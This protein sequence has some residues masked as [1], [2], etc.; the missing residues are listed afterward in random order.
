MLLELSAG[1]RANQ[2]V[3]GDLGCGRQA[4]TEHAKIKIQ[5][6]EQMADELRPARNSRRFSV[7][8]RPPVPKKISEEEE[9]RVSVRN[10]SENPHVGV[11]R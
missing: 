8:Q 7:L 4:D 11:V 3:W 1:I 5:H 2:R 6:F 10:F 9:R